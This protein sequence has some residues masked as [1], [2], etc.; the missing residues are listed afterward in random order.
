MPGDTGGHTGA[1]ETEMK[2]LVLPATGHD[3]LTLYTA[4][5]IRVVHQM[6]SHN[7]AML[8]AAITDNIF[9]LETLDLQSIVTS[10]EIHRQSVCAK[11]LHS[12]QFGNTKLKFEGILGY[13]FNYKSFN[14]M[15]HLYNR[16][17]G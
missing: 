17:M 11:K 13:Y 15:W 2:T 14:Y 12:Y 5:L 10:L 16:A 1:G 8:P 7:E 9:Y 6:C 4:L 3:A